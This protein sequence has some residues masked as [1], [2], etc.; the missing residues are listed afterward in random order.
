MKLIALLKWGIIILVATLLF[1]DWAI[2]RPVVA[3]GKTWHVSTTGSDTTGNGSETAPFATIQHGVELARNN[4]IVLVH[5]GTYFENVH[6]WGGAPPQPQVVLKSLAGP[7]ATVID[8]RNL[9]SVITIEAGVITV[10]GFTLQNGGGSASLASA[11]YGIVVYPYWET[12]ATIRNNIVKNSQLRGGIGIRGGSETLIE[13]NLIVSNTVTALYTAGGIHVDVSSGTGWSIIRNN[14]IAHNQGYAGGLKLAVCCGPINFHVDVINNTI[15]SNTAFYGGGI[16]LAAVSVRLANNI[17]AMNTATYSGNDLYGT[18]TGAVIEFND[19]GDGQLAGSNGNFS[20]PPLLVDPIHGN[21]HLT[22]DSLCVNAG[23]ATGAPATDFEGDARPY[24]SGVDI[25]A[26]EFVWPPDG[27][28]P[29]SSAM[30]PAFSDPTFAVNWHGADQGGS[31]IDHYDIQ[32]KDGLQGSWT[33]WL[34]HTHNLQA[35]YEGDIGHTYYFQSRA[36]DHAGNT[37]SYPGGTGDTST[38]VG[39][40]LGSSTKRAAFPDD[41]VSGSI[42][43]YTIIVRNTQSID[44]AAR[45]TDTLPSF[46]RYISDSL[47]SSAEPAVYVADLGENG[48]ILWNGAV[49]LATPVSITFQVELLSDDPANLPIRNTAL[50]DDGW[51]HLYER[52]VFAPSHDIYLPLS[53]KNY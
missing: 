33:N 2:I 9:D 43:T 30:S 34:T 49:S 50:I 37:E 32:V 15:V 53:M 10:E 3:Q 45:L 1:S 13:N 40:N 46:T 24:G 52:V 8:G 12:H 31:G 48:S 6:F 7:A 39:P 25:G 23:T 27:L 14:V 17:I 5:P 4:D 21:Y 41:L 29:V 28:S 20:S 35:T 51:G 26:D 22:M 19:I 18:L 36:I 38:F 16:D 47:T 11:G 44:A 42:L